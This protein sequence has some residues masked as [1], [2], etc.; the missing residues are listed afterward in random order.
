MPLRDHFRP[1]TSKAAS[2]EALHAV[3]PVIILQQ[4]RKVLPKGYHCEPRVHVGNLIEIDIA[5][6]ENDDR[7]TTYSDHQSNG[8]GVATLPWAPA[9]PS[10]TV[11]TDPPEFDVYEVQIYDAE[12]ERQLVA[13][14][15]IVSPRNKDRPEARNAFVA[16]CAALLQQGVCVSIV[17]LVT[18]RHA[19]LYAELME[20][21]GRPIDRN[22]A[23]LPGTYATTCRWILGFQRAKLETWTHTLNLG[24]VL[25][26]LPIWLTSTLAIPLDL[27]QSY[28][29]AC[30]DLSIP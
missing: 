24:Q 30:E 5:A 6:F 21:I 3:W 8:H 2:W 20:F 11:E 17:D 18:V 29:K 4:I 25:P 19:N 28:E 9:L 23:E 16:K 15:E 22:G 14:I 13:A 7:P 10:M 27:E 1:P 12:R 26:V